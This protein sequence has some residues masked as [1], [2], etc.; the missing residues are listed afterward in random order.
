MSDHR[1]YTTAD[2]TEGRKGDV[3]AEGVPQ[4]IR[5][6][7]PPEFM[8]EAGTWTPEHIFAAALASCFVTTFKAIAEFSKFDFFSLHVEVEAILEKEPGGYSFTRALVKPSLEIGAG[9]DQERA[10]RLMEKAERACL[11]SRSVKSQI[12]LQPALV[13]RAIQAVGAAAE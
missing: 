2:W 3:S 9:A 10:L 11:I 5:F 8:G 6:S 12:E 7:A 13:V 4:T 1:Y